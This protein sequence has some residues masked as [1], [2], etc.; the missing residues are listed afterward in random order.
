MLFSFFIFSLSYLIN[1]FPQEQPKSTPHL[2]TNGYLKADLLLYYYVHIF[3]QR[4]TQDPSNYTLRPYFIVH[5]A[6][7]ARALFLSR[8]ISLMF[9]LEPSA[10]FSPCCVSDSSM[11]LQF[12]LYYISYYVDTLLHAQDPHPTENGAWNKR[13]N[14]TI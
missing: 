3:Y 6:H 7:R 10:Y 9:A 2:S 5:Y 11:Y 8:C 12:S 4:P 14:Q 1:T 13:E